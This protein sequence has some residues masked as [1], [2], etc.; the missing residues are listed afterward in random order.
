MI[1]RAGEIARGEIGIAR[2]RRRQHAAE[3]LAVALADDERRALRG[4]RAHAAG[5]VHV[6]V[7]EDEE[8]DRLARDTSSARPPASS[9]T[10]QSLT[11]ASNTIR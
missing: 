1:A 4:E 5:V 8:P 10:C 11:G 7:R 6:V 9:S 3:V 2:E